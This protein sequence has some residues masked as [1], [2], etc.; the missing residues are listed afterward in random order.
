MGYPV[1]VDKTSAAA[2]VGHTDL[3]QIETPLMPDRGPWL[4]S[5]AYSQY[6]EHELTSGTLWKLLA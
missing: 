4:N 1:F 6:D 2:L 5:L 3:R